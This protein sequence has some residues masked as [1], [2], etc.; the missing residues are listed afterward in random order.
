MSSKRDIIPARDTDFDI[1]QQDVIS[2]CTANKVP[3]AIP[4]ATMTSIAALQ[5]D[6]K[7]AWEAA[8]DKGSRTKQQTAEK[9]EARKNY[10]AALRPFLQSFVQNN[11]LVPDPAKEGMNIKPHSTARTKVPAPTTIPVLM[12]KPGTGTALKLFYKQE[13][14]NEGV[15]GRGKPSGVKFCDVVYKIGGATVPV[16]PA[17]CD[18]SLLMTKS[19]ATITF[20]A[21][22]VGLKVYFF[23]R[24]LNVN[25]EPGMW[26]TLPISAFIPG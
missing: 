10:E 6:W 13:P 1:F 24:W 11:V 14:E 23:A 12:L 5:Q 22:Q 3:W 15:S 9:T 20:T 25:N 19:N 26:N 17:E 21:E 16:S 7:D 8:K 18:N 4:D 2:T